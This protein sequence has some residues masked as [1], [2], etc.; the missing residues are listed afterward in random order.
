MLADSRP[1]L[2]SKSESKT[3]PGCHRSMVVSVDRVE[4]HANDSR[5]LFLIRLNQVWFIPER[6][7]FAGDFGTEREMHS[8]FATCAGFDYSVSTVRKHNM[9]RVASFQCE[10]QHISAPV[11]DVRQSQGERPARGLTVILPANSG[12]ATKRVNSQVRGSSY[13]KT[14]I[15]YQK[16]PQATLT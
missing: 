7:I 9:K 5:G 1:I 14:S 8:Q 6:A 16:D 4:H 13:D 12:H 10:F 11:M 2:M 15:N 3:M